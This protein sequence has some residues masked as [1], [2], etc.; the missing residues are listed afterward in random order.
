METDKEKMLFG[1]L[2]DTVKKV[3][4]GAYDKTDQLMELTNQQ[5]YPEDI[6]QL[7]E[8]FGM[9][10]VRVESREF[11]LEQLLEELEVKNRK[12]EESLQ[13]VRLLESIQSHM[14]KFVPQSVEK[15]ISA[16]PEDPDLDKHDRHISALFLDIEGYTRLSEKNSQERMNFLV[17]TYFSKFLDIIVANN[18]DINETSGDGL[19]ILF[20][21]DN[22]EKN[23][24]NAVNAALDIQKKTCEINHSLKGDFDPVCV[25]MG[26]NSGTA[27]LGSTRLQ[28]LAG[29]RLTYTASGPVTNIASRVCSAA[30]SGKV[31]ITENTAGL[32]KNRFLLS[33]PEHLRM[34]NIS[35][36][37]K[38]MAV[39]EKQARFSD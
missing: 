31:L 22:P 21:A 11:N 8:A 19:M 1:I 5:K 23:A 3:S 35:R 25:N 32:L 14:R 18:G 2:L 12:L 39:L 38:V 13:R 37:I 33:L 10:I 4:M 15:L 30:D 6:A 20:H 27:A 26:V 29:D 17:E 34:K 7:A 24:Y 36:P 9:M 16:N 28:G